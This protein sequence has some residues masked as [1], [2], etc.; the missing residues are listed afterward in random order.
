MLTRMLPFVVLV[1]AQTAT[2]QLTPEQVTRLETVTSVALSPDARHI[3]Y[4]ISRPRAP[5]EDT[6]A[7]LRGF[8]EL[9]ID[10]E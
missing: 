6:L 5:E 7:G 10:R 2:A 1:A 3:A 9:W 8:S 4:T